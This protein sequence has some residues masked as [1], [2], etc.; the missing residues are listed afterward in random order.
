MKLNTRIFLSISLFIFL[1]TTSAIGQYW[2]EWG[3]NLSDYSEFGDAAQMNDDGTCLVASGYSRSKNIPGTIYAFEWNGSDW[4]LKGDSVAGGDNDYDQFGLDLNITNNC[5]TIIVGAGQYTSSGTPSLGYTRIYDWDGSEWVQRGSISPIIRSGFAVDISEDGNRIA[6]SANPNFPG[7]HVFDWN[8]SEWVQVGQTLIIGS[9]SF[10]HGSI[11]L[12]SDGSSFILNNQVFELIN[13]EWVQKGSDLP[14][15][16]KTND[17]NGDGNIISVATGTNDIDTVINYYWDGTNWTQRGSAIHNPLSQ[18]F[19]F[20]TTLTD[21]GNVLAVGDW[22]NNEVLVYDWNETDWIPRSSPVTAS[23]RAAGYDQQLDISNDGR[24]VLVASHNTNFVR[25]YVWCPEEENRDTVFACDSY[26]WSLNDSTYTSS[27]VDTVILQDKYGCNEYYYL[28]LNIGSTTIK[29]T[30][31]FICG[32]SSFTWSE[33]NIT[34]TKD[35]A[36][37]YTY[38]NGGCTA[39]SSLELRIGSIDTTTIEPII[40]DQYYRWPINGQ[41]Y[42]SSGTYYHTFYNT[43]GCDS[44]LELVLTLSPPTITTFTESACESYEWSQTGLSYANTGMY[45]DTVPNQY[46]CDSILALDLTI[47]KDSVRDEQVI[48][49]GESMTWIDGKTYSSDTLVYHTLINQYNCDSVVIL[50]LSIYDYEGEILTWGSGILYISQ[51]QTAHQWYSCS[52]DS[53]INGATNYFYNPTVP[54]AYQVWVSNGSC[55][56]TLTCMNSDIDCNNP[57]LASEGLNEALLNNN[58]DWFYYVNT[59]GN[60]ESLIIS[61]CDQTTEDTHLE[62]WSDCSTQIS[63][64]QGECEDQSELTYQLSNSDTLFIRWTAVNNSNFTWELS[65]SPILALTPITSN[66]DIYLIST[67]T[68]GEYRVSEPYIAAEVFST[69]GQYV[70]TFSQN[71]LIDLK[72]QPSGVYLVRIYINDLIVSRKVLR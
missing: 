37:T 33:N 67:E 49:Q 46:G 41:S 20:S 62:L 35:T 52:G 70:K 25:S 44:V 5:N 43:S 26:T 1:G 69:R 2:K 30:N 39:H 59:S 55:W 21:D 66:S 14:E 8:G 13:N 65:K 63:T 9:E 29:D 12:S 68:Q 47:L 53:V 19:A 54:G 16:L 18:N 4:V 22:W 15:D 11:E 60:E 64:S 28:V 51:T 50:D 38:V 45:Y 58:F 42:F 48:C 6:T 34:Y 36:L 40:C 71:E 72:S 61:S 32:S 31:V 23:S 57:K 7:T 27:T 24:M 17:M 3:S 10:W 56:D